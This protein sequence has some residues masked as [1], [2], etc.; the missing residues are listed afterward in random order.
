M[1]GR[2]QPREKMDEDE[3]GGGKSAVLLSVVNTSNLLGPI[4]S[5]QRIKVEEGFIPRVV[6]SYVCS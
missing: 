2:K 6:I 1:E 4:A 5:S 3:S